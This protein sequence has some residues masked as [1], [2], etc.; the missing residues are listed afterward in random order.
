M[1]CV[2]AITFALGFNGAAVVTNL[3]NVHDLAPN[4]SAIVFSIINLFGTT[5]GITAPMT[6]AYFTQE[7]NTTNEWNQIF[8]IAS[9]LFIV[10]T[11]IFMCFGSTDIQYW[12]DSN[13][14]K[15]KDK[16][17]SISPEKYISHKK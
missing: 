5:C 16:E 11:V 12:N 7:N 8:T 13:F 2:L 14:K 1:L 3:Q 4:Y 6:I 9:I 10:P 17:T 15:T